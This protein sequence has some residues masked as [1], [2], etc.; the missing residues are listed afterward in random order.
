MCLDDLRRLVSSVAVAGLCVVWAGCSGSTGGMAD[1]VLHNGKV[2]TVDASVPDGEAVAVKDGKIKAAVIFG[3]DLDE[4]HILPSM[5][6]WQV[7]AREAAAVGMK[8]NTFLQNVG[9][10]RK[11]LGEC[12]ERRGVRLSSVVP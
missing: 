4:E 6:D 5:E 10:A 7:F 3:D 1:L 12:L 11:L 8:L 2:V 9:R